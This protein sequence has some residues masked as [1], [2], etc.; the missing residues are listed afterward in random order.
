MTRVSILLLL[1]TW[2]DLQVSTWDTLTLM[3]MNNFEDISF[4]M[5]SASPAIK[6]TTFYSQGVDLGQ[7]K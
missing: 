7:R 5:I 6:Q 1:F 4:L 2:R 3:G